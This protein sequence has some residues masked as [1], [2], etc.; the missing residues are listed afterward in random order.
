MLSLIM[1]L[2]LIAVSILVVFIIRFV[3]VFE[4][5]NIFGFGVIVCDDVGILVKV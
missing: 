3:L 5:G 4:D 1:F 2:F